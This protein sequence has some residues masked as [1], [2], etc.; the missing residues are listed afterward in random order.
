MCRRGCATI[1]MAALLAILRLQGIMDTP[2]E[3]FAVVER[4]VRLYCRDSD[5]DE[6]LEFIAKRYFMEESMVDPKFFQDEMVRDCFDEAEVKQLDATVAIAST[7]ASFKKKVYSE[8]NRR[9]VG[10]GGQGAGRGGR[11]PAA[12]AV[13]RSRSLPSSAASRWRGVACPCAW[14]APSS[15]AWSC[16]AAD[17]RRTARSRARLRADPTRTP[18]LAPWGAVVEATCESAIAIAPAVMPC[19][20]FMGH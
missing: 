20:V 1:P 14:R 12:G 18:R 8:A 2:A 15:S 16:G 5:E 13:Q 7:S 4:V 6:I 9:A 10:R 11:A 17:V 3:E 19:P